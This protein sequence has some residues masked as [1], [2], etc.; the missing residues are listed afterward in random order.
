MEFFAN[1]LRI[2]ND[3]LS[4]KNCELVTE[5][6]QNI[7]IIIGHLKNIDGELTGK[8]INLVGDREFVLENGSLSIC[9]HNGRMG[10]NVLKGDLLSKGGKFEI[11]GGLLYT[12]KALEITNG[13]FSLVK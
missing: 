11:S 8:N 13:Q 12:L 9:S 7:Q 2:R 5:V 1:G 3:D 6:G 4:L 10:Y